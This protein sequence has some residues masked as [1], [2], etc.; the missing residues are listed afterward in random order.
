MHT[1]FSFSLFLLSL[2]P[3][4][5]IIK[6][7]L[8]IDLTLIIYILLYAFAVFKLLV[9][10]ERISFSKV[11]SVF[12]LWVLVLLIGSIYSPAQLEGLFKTMEFLFLGVSLIFFSR[13]FIKNKNDLNKIIFYMLINSTLT[14]YLVLIDFYLSGME[15]F[16]YQAFGVVVPI[17]LSMLGATTLLI[18]IFMFYFK[19]ISLVTFVFTT[20]PSVSVMGIAASKGPVIAFLITVTLMSPL[21]IKK[22]NIKLVFVTSIA[23]FLL[24]RIQFVKESLDVLFRRFARTEYDMS[25]SIRINSYE[26]AIEAFKSSPF[27]G[28]GTAVNYPDYPHNFFLEILSENG[29]FLLLI[30][31]S[32]ITLLVFQYLR[33]IVKKANTFSETII[34]SLI[35]SSV[36]SLMFSFTYVDH[37]YL[38]LSIGLLI[39]YNKINKFEKTEVVTDKTKKKNYRFKRYRIVW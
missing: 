37:K 12:Y 22:F 6:G 27:L 1:K 26:K 28:K 3:L 36:V 17:P 24:T 29:V 33:F 32:L 16:R 7:A 5:Y 20:L 11:D 34:L 23:I 19:K 13:V 39:V 18:S 31:F 15:S 35:I 21:L 2:V 25:T 10:K 30:I 9:K 8:P 4:G 14:G 38:F